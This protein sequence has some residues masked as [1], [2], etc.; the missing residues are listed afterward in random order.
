MRML[1]ILLFILAT[2]IDAG[3]QLGGRSSVPNAERGTG[4]IQ[5]T[6]LY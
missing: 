3:P 4:S 1:F 2:S 6:L 5:D